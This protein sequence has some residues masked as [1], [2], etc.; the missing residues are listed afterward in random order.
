M[1]GVVEDIS[2]VHT[3]DHD[4]SKLAIDGNTFLLS[5]VNSCKVLIFFIIVYI[6]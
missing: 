6:I 5:L 2:P 4:E 3:K 1:A